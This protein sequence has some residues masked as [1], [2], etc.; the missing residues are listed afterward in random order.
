LRAVLLLTRMPQVSGRSE[1]D[2]K[3]HGGVHGEEEGGAGE[4]AQGWGEKSCCGEESR[5]RSQAS[6]E[7]EIREGTQTPGRGAQ[8]RDDEKA[9]DIPGEGRSPTPRSSGGGSCTGP[10]A[11]P[12]REHSERA[13][14]A[15]CIGSDDA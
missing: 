15:S 4:E 3:R 12:R 14:A 5:T 1:P 6:R 11:I 9:S 8:G 13:V 10:A 7:Q 2:D